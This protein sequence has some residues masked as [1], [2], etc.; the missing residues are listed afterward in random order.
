MKLIIAGSRDIYDYTLIKD[1]IDSQCKFDIT[2]I[3]SGTCS[4]VDTC[5]ER[6]AKEHN[7]KLTK[8]PANWTKYGKAA[9][10]IRNQSMALYADVAIVIH[11]TCSKGSMNMLQC[12]K[13]LNKPCID[14][15]IN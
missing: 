2:E 9:G 4:G 5:G 12:M 1:Y 8:F 15:T 7:I 13:Q 6:Y 3:V 10:P 14:I 11:H